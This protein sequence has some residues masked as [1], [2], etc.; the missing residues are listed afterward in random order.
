MPYEPTRVDQPAPAKATKESRLDEVQKKIDEL[1]KER[2][3][4]LNE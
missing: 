2:E 3:R 4:I 1:V